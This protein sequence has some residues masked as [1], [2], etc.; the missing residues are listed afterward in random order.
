MQKWEY[1]VVYLKDSDVAQDQ[2]EVDIHLD[3]DKFS[4][5]LSIYGEAGWEMVS[6]QWEERG[7]RASFKRPAG[8]L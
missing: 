5:K 8:I 2:P 1:L 4:E 7:A 6:F 3:A